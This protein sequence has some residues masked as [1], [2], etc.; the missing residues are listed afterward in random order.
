MTTDRDNTRKEL[1]LSGLA[2]WV[3]LCEIHH[4]V[5]QDNP[6][7]TVE[8]VQRETLDTIRSLVSDGLVEVG[9]LAPGGRFAAW[10]TPLEESLER[11]AAAYIDNFEHETGWLWVFW[12]SLT[13]EGRRRAEALQAQSEG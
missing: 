1:L 13:D 9:N 4:Q 2:D 6:G 12:L 10:D 11:I 3:H 5:Q 8:E 7:L